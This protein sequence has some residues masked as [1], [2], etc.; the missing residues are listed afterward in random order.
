MINALGSATPDWNQA[1]CK[2]ECKTEGKSCPDPKKPDFISTGGKCECGCD[3]S[4]HP[5]TIPGTYPLSEG[6]GQETLT[7]VSI[8]RGDWYKWSAPAGKVVSIARIISS[9]H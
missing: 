3:A 9:G 1:Q 2:L 5:Y 6:T 7:F 4:K 8:T